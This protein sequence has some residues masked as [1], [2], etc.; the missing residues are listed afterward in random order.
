MSDPVTTLFLRRHP[1]NPVFADVRD[2]KGV[3]Q[4]Y[5]TGSYA[6]A[7]L[8]GRGEWLKANGESARRLARAL[9]RTL[10]WIHN[11]S[12]DEI[13]RET[14]EQLRGNNPTLFAEVLRATLPS[15]PPDG[16][17]EPD[18]VRAVLKVLSVSRADKKLA[19][20]DLSKTYTNE[21]AAAK[22]K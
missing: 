15:F 16:T 10:N 20:L 13:T 19:D 4:L 2:E 17:F 3:R 7:S 11:H 8:I 1:N 18:G 12:T 9:N 14:P 21:F 6:S 22:W 5:G